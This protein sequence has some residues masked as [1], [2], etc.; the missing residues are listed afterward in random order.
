MTFSP[1]RLLLSLGMSASLA[2]PF[3][4]APAS[5]QQFNSLVKGDGPAVYFFAQDGKRY[6]FPNL[7]VYQTW[8]PTG[9]NITLLKADQ[10]ASMP[11]G[12][13]VT[14][15]P[16]VALVK[17]TTDP[18]V[19]ALSKGGVLRWIAS[20]ELARVL[21]GSDWNTKVFDVPDV[22]F[23]N[24][25]IGTPI[26]STADY[27]KNLEAGSVT[28]PGDN[29]AGVPSSLPTSQ[30]PQA[31]VN[32][33]KGLADVDVYLSSSQATLNQTVSINAKVSQYS[34]PIAKIEIFR[35]SSSQPMASC[36]KTM[37]CLAQFFI[38]VAP[39]KEKFYAVA[40]NVN[41]ERFESPIH[42]NLVVAA[43]SNNLQTTVTP[44]TLSV[45]A[46]GSFSAVITSNL[47]VESH[48]VFARIPGVADPVLWKDCKTDTTCAGSS[49]FYRSMSLY[50]E[51]VSE[52]QTYV[53]PDAN[54]AVVGGMA[55][56]P[57]LSL[58]GKTAKNTYT[59]EI[60][61]PSGEGILPTSFAEGS[62]QDGSILTLCDSVCSVTINVTK[63]VDVTA[64]AYVGG[65]YE[66]SDT[67]ELP[68][69][70]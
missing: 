45:G 25:Q 34:A 23:I 33:Q 61:P 41:G 49:P 5:A 21:Y 54:L 19:Y 47:V 46:R 10:L 50:S 40:T 27:D 35:E 13:N 42:T 44:Q 14:Y 57:K 63:P 17:V 7:S 70:P 48:K 6:A 3:A 29:V 53:S 69:E 37:E 15:K 20:E 26:T 51:V 1:S 32:P 55:P 2:L 12:G 62:I 24:Y 36:D 66:A 4:A 68:F 31:P 8:Y 39:A 30:L 56:K 52:G 58:T 22:F 64:Y 38:Q 16:G 60:V 9:S 18:K 43:V 11:L 59:F 28:N 67:F 65:K